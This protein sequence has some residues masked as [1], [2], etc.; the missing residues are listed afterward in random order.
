MDGMGSDLDLQKL[1][2][3]SLNEGK[4]GGVAGLKGISTAWMVSLNGGMG[5]MVGFQPTHGVVFVGIQNGP[6]FVRGV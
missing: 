3:R 1:I 5:W 6:K 4:V 2:T